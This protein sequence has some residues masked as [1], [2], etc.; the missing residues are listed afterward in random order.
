MHLQHLRAAAIVAA[1]LTVPSLSAQPQFFPNSQKYKDSSIPNATG[2]SGTASIEARALFNRD[3]TTDLE[4]TSSG[5]IAKV[6]L[7]SPSTP[8]LNFDGSDGGTFSQNLGGLGPHEQLGITANVRGVDG[9]RTDVVS[10]DEIVKRRPDLLTSINAPA[11]AFRGRTVLVRATFRELNGDVGARANFRLYADGTLIDRVEGA[12]VDANGHVDAVFAPVIDKSGDVALTVAAEDVDPGDWDDSNNSAT[13]HITVKEP[14]EFYS[15]NATV[16]E[17]DG[18]H[19]SHEQYSWGDFTTDNKGI[20]QGFDVSAMIRGEV[21]HVAMKLTASAST[22]GQPLYSGETSEFDGP[23]RTWDGYCSW[24]R[25]QPEVTVCY[26]R[27]LGNTTVEVSFGASDVVYRSYGWA[28]RRNPFAPEE[29]RFEWNTTFVQDTVMARLGSN[30]A[31]N[32]DFETAGQLWHAAPSVPV[33]APQI[34]QQDRAFT[35][36][37]DSFFNMDVCEEVHDWRSTRRGSGFGF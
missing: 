31:M 4:V 9:A 17:E 3:R 30:V 23:F 12:W 25:T 15:W 10:V 28:T 1:A 35:C 36:M 18:R 26:D 5:A 8:A 29:P 7:Q 14:A 37:H 21:P 27:D 24:G 34:F 19:F 20:N 13:V 6:H 33:G 32:I 16:Y 2:R 22:D 11:S